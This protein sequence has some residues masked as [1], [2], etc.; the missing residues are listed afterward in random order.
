MAKRGG[1]MMGKERGTGRCGVWEL[2]KEK[3]WPD[4]IWLERVYDIYLVWFWIEIVF[5]KLHGTQ[6]RRVDGHPRPKEGP[7]QAA[8]N[9][10]LTQVEDAINDENSSIQI[11]SAKM[12][13]LHIFKG[14]AIMIKGKKRK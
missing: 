9:I 5:F 6:K 13:E 3:G 1:E 7:Q 14:D 2:L 8:R 10:A 12:N 4:H 11:S